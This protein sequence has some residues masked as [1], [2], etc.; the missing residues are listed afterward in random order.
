MNFAER[1][2]SLLILNNLSQNELA[3]RTGLTTAAICRYCRGNRQPSIDNLVRICDALNVS[4][5]YLLGRVYK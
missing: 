3:K 1:L 5:D 2:N 4:A